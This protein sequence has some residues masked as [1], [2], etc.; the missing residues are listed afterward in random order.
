MMAEGGAAIGMQVGKQSIWYMQAQLP[1]MT[2]L[3][4]AGKFNECIIVCTKLIPAI[5]GL[6]N[7]SERLHFMAYT[8][9]RQGAAFINIGELDSARDVLMRRV[10]SVFYSVNSPPEDSVRTLSI[11]LYARKSF[12]HASFHACFASLLK[13]YSIFLCACTCRS[14]HRR[15]HL[16]DPHVST[17]MMKHPVR[18]RSNQGNSG[19]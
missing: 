2:I 7:T 18:K 10:R 5:A 11:V 16:H 1:L 9:L 14:Q 17:F 3:S 15:I 13:R 12:S 8:Y 4:V 19:P 6:T